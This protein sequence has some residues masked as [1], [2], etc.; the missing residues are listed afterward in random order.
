MSKPYVNGLLDTFVKAGFLTKEESVLVFNQL[1]KTGKVKE[2]NPM[3]KDAQ[4][5]QGGI[6]LGRMAL[7]WLGKHL[8]KPVANFVTKTA[9]GAIRNFVKGSPKLQQQLLPG[10][11]H[12]NMMQ[13]GIAGTKNYFKQ[14]VPNAL[15]YAKQHPF[16][17]AKKVLWDSPVGQ[18]ASMAGAFEGAGRVMAR[19]QPNVMGEAIEEG[20]EKLS[21]FNRVKDALNKQASLVGLGRGALNLTGNI[22]GYSVGEKA[23]DKAMDKMSKKTKKVK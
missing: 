19:K 8:A 10:M 23:M 21:Q 16:L 18:G 20:V 7:P 3:R 22:V 15:N 13:R 17:A 14:T 12:P 5:I 9:P 2:L 1:E 4:L 11:T 6:A